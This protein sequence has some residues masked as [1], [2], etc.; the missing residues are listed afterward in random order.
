MSCL[1]PS[2]QRMWDQSS[3]TSNFRKVAYRSIRVMSWDIF[4]LAALPLLSH[5]KWR[6]LNLTTICY[7]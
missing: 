5:S 4:S 1:S 3:Y 6:G 7:S 2:E